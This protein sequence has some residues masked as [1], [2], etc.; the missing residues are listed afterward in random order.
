MYLNTKG[1]TIPKG[2]GMGGSTVNSLRLFFDEE[3]EACISRSSGP[4]FE[5]GGL[6]STKMFVVEALEVW[7]VGSEAASMSQ[8]VYR[9]DR[10]R[11]LNQA[12]KVDKAQFAST[13]W[14]TFCKRN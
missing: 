2:F 5:K 11:L 9:K 4:S 14:T 13:L 3:L 1:A 6:A 12:R 7:G 10:E 8:E